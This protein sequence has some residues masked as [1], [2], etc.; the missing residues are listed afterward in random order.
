M[1]IQVEKGRAEK[2]PCELLLLFSFDS[3]EHWKVPSRRW[4]WSGK[5][6]YPL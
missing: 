4:I 1:N 2:Y 6:L 3:P 5:G